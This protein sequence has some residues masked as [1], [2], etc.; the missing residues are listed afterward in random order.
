MTKQTLIALGGG[1][2]SAILAMAFL[3]GERGSL[4]LV[5]FAPLPLFMVGL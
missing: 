2:L 3:A 4:F 5:Y 1:G